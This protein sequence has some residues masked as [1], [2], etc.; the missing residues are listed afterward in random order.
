MTEKDLT[1]AG[2]VSAHGQ[3]VIAEWSPITVTTTE[4]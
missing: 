2:S 3:T 1:A 4:Q